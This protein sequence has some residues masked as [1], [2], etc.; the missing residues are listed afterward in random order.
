MNHQNRLFRRIFTCF[1]VCYLL[2]AAAP[3][4]FAGGS[5][6]G[7][8]SAADTLIAEKQYDQAILFLTE[9]VKKYPND[10]NKAQKR[11]R[12]IVQLRDEYNKVADELLETVMSDT[13]IENSEK[14]LAL[15]RRLQDIE[16]PQNPSVRNFIARVQDLALFNFN[17]RRLEQIFNSGRTFIAQGDYPAA[18]N[19]YAGGLDIYR[20]AFY[21]AGYG[22][23]VENTVRNNVSAITA[24]INDFPGLQ[25]R[26]APIVAEMEQAGRD[27][28]PITRIEGIFN[29]LVPVLDEIIQ[30][31]ETFY[32]AASYVEEELIREQAIDS[33]IGDR[34]YLSF[35]SRLVRG[36]S[37]AEVREGMIGTVEAYWNSSLSRV[38]TS[39]AGLTNRSY[40]TAWNQLMNHEYNTAGAAFRGAAAFSA[41]PLALIDKWDEFDQWSGDEKMNLY[42]QA[43]TPARAGDFLKYRALSDT[44]GHLTNGAVLG[45]RYET[46]PGRNPQTLASW[47]NGTMTPQAADQAEAQY[48]SSFALLFTDVD[49]LLAQ[50]TEEE[51]LIRNYIANN[52]GL[53]NRS[54]DA[55][56]YFFNAESFINDLRNWVIEGE[57]SSAVRQYTI[58]NGEIEKSLRSRQNELDEG[59]RLLQ[60]AAE[61]DGTVSHYPA[62]GLAIL[63]RMDQSLGADIAE[64]SALLGRYADEKN[65]IISRS[66]PAALYASARTMENTLVS[67]QNQGQTLAAT[68]RTQVAQAETFRQD[69]ER[70]FREAQ[71]ALG[72]NN[73]AV[74]RDRIERAAERYN[75]SLA[76]QAS[77]AV[78]RDWDTR[79]VTLGNEINRLENEVVVRDVRTLVNTARTS[80][81]NGNFEQAE[82]QLVRAQNRWH[83]TNAGEDEEV[84]YWLNLVRGA[85]SLRSGRTIPATAPLYAEMS[86]LLSDARKNYDEGVRLLTASRRNEGV[87]KFTEARQ[88][89]Q[90]VKLMFPLNQEAG[91]LELRMDQVTDPAIFNQTF[92]RRF[93]DAVAGTQPN[94]R[95]VE[96]FAELQN[97]ALINPGYPGMAAAIYQ[98]EINMGYRLPPPNPQDLARS[99]ELTREAQRIINAANVSQS[100]LAIAQQQ[101]NEALRLNPNNTDAQMIKD[102]IANLMGTGTVVLTRAAEDQYQQAVNEYTRNNFLI[103]NAIVEQLLQD[104]RNRGS[105]KIIELQ[106]RIQSRL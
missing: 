70:L 31:Q 15:I 35:I 98:A 75:G 58:A 72:Q 8:I 6:E 3:P 64:G 103:A 45:Q 69:G 27:N 18:L 96:S 68:A 2:S 20:D 17:R 66:D 55:L 29:R 77:D 7:D 34:S 57:Y 51:G 21:S 92:T 87:A 26:L 90:E 13:D 93:N 73:F 46:S 54:D 50:V 53:A 86:Q 84:I 14:V 10:F 16:D 37:T 36:P 76:I 102:R 47:R 39:L 40:Q 78:K 101:I 43:I 82:E 19:A 32:S 61:A 56:F 83:V 88:K 4:L 48:R 85:L 38:E 62:E 80:Y 89:T 33:T 94:R 52:A 105:S 106:R 65:E 12:T 30:F 100:Q 42:A 22:E 23:E 44:S 11:I 71:N 91:I 9:Y 67:M 95:S 41:Y 1:A 24:R 79:F 97:L 60:G 63:N 49:N 28:A 5:Q 74:A 59:I 81:N 99:A 104:S 25:R